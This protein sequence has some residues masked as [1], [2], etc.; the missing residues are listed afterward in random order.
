MKK[1]LATLFAA[2]LMAPLASALPIE[3]LSISTGSAKH[4][5]K[6]EIANDPEE[7]TLGL[8]NRTALGDQAGMLF[9]FGD[10]RE[11][12][13]W[14]KN[15]LISLDMIFV[16]AD[17]EIVAIA[18]NTVPGSLR[19]INPGV[20]VKGVVELKAG[21]AE[22]LGIEPGHTVHHTIFGNAND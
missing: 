10:P 19:R 12:S 2:I 16:G 20:P 17:G 9:D 6:V 8:M 22:A 15:T 11:T 3:D 4:A 1:R 14:M 7:I 5:F 21:R 13:M 18:R